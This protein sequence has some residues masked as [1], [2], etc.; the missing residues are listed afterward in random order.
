MTV[1][2]HLL[3]LDD[4]A[5]F[6]GVPKRTL[7]SWRYRGEGPVGYRVGRHVRF[8][9]EDVEAWLQQC[10]EADREN[11]GPLPKTVIQ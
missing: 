5:A 10:R 3:S 9:R 7:Y 6:L 4:L 11:T 1:D 2:D 8:R